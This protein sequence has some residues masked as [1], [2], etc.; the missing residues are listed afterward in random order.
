MN[1]TQEFCR[2]TTN[3]IARAVR[4]VVKIVKEKQQEAIDELTEKFNT[5]LEI[6]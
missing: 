5:A 3:N 4:R 6:S 2:A 1:V